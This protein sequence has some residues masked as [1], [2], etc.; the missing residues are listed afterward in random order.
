MFSDED[1]TNI[2]EIAGASKKIDPTKI[3]R[4]GVGFCSVFHITDVPSFISRNF[5][6]VFDPN[7]LYLKERVTSTKPGMRIDFKNSL[8]ESLN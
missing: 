2:C 6:T 3:G 1:F 5:Y 8:M 7:L 4:F